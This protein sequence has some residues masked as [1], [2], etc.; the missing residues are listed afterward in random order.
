M[1]AQRWWQDCRRSWKACQQGISAGGGQP[2]TFFKKL[3]DQVK[4]LELKNKL[5]GIYRGRDGKGSIFVWASGNGGRYKVMPM[6][7]T[8]IIVIVILVIVITVGQLQLWRLRDFDFHNHSL[9]HQWERINTLVS[10]PP[11]SMII[12]SIKVIIIEVISSTPCANANN[13]RYSEPCSATIATTYS[14]GTT[15]ERQI[16]TTDLHHKYDDDDSD[17]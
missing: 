1:G 8:T 14:S 16:V 4:I 5:Q 9:K 2:K 15:S 6:K 7:I 3:N 12:L 17:W 11:W 13:W 10:V